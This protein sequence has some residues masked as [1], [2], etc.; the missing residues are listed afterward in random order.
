LL[1]VYESDEGELYM[2]EQVTWE[3]V[4]SCLYRPI[5]VKGVAHNVESLAEIRR[6]LE[7]YAG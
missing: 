6:R 4:M 5:F 1:A 2:K 3:E 7:S